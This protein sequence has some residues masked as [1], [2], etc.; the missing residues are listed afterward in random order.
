MAASPPESAFPPLTARA[1]LLGERIDTVGLERRDAVS[2]TPLAF[3]VGEQGFAVVFRYGVVVLIGL[4]PLAEDEVLRGIGPRVVSPFALREEETARLAP[5]GDREERVEPDGAI[6][7]AD[8]SPQRLLVVA[9]ALAKSAALADD[10]RQ[11][12]QV[13]DTI[14]PWARE[15]ARRGR[16]PAGRRAMIRLIGA[17]LLVEHRVS[18]RVAVSDKPDILWDRPDLERLY[19]RLETEYELDERAEVLNR[20]LGLIGQTARLMTDLI[21]TERSLRLE[22]AIVVL[23]VAEIGLTLYQ[24]ASGVAG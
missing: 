10:E 23:I 21:D 3:G 8:R 4:D 2:T 16:G 5:A 1:V 6:C 14:E 13:F 19:A 15:L 11:V 18:G 17:A 7:I 12:A 20:K 22:W 9:D 24:M